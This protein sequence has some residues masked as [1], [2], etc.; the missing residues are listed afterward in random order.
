[1]NM[2]HLARSLLLILFLAGCTAPTATRLVVPTSLPSATSLPTVTP[3]PTRTPTCLPTVTP[4]PEPTP[5]PSATPAPTA[6]PDPV[7]GWRIPDLRALTYGQG[8]ISIGEIYNRA[9]G[10]TSYLIS[11]PSADGLR[12]TGLL[13]VPDGNGP[14]PVI[15]ANRGHI[16]PTRYRPGMDSRAFSDYAARRGYLVVAPDYRGY[17]GSDDGPNAFYTGYAI[18]VLSLIPLAQKLPMA[19]PGN[20]GMWGHSRGGS[21]TITALTITDQIAAAVVYAPAP[22]DLAE[23]YARRFRQSG[24]NPGSDTWP[25]PPD[26][27]PAAYTR[28][29]PIT[30]FDAVQAPVMLHHGTA[31]RTVPAEA[32]IAIADALRANG[33]SVVLHLYDSGPHTLVGAQERLYL[34]RTLEFFAQHLGTP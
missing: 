1:M 5:M 10:Y 34:E 9:A 30:Y 19:R 3:V 26:V 14:F 24:G 6:M 22:A 33:K 17:A 13:H 31:D 4:T 18:D 15:I 23:D 20:V 7:A 27:D 11:Y 16:D 12:L 2:Y 29:S 21:I 25:F 28:V 32:S 8:D